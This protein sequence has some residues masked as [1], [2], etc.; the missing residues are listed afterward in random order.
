MCLSDQVETE[1]PPQ[2]RGGVLRSIWRTKEQLTKEDELD[3]QIKT[4]LKELI[5]Y[6]VFFSALLICECV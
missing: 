2:R 4:T 3:I 1:W 6:C 5:I